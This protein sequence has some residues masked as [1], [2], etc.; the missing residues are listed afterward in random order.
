MGILKEWLLFFMFLQT[1]NWAL[2]EKEIA[3]LQPSAWSITEKEKK[4]K[5]LT[6]CSSEAVYNDIDPVRAL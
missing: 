2:A 6:T 4:K 3:N 1:V 5:L